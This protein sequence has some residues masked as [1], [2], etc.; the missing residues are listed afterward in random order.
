[1]TSKTRTTRTTPAKREETPKTPAPTT[2]DSEA[3]ATPHA[4][5]DAAVDEH[6]NEAGY[7]PQ[8]RESENCHRPVNPDFYGLCDTHWVTRPDLRKA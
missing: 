3:D 8:C 4:D 5:D 7:V 1:M 6:G 2:P